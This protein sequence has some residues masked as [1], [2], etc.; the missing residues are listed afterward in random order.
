MDKLQ[1]NRVKVVVGVLYRINQQNNL[2]LLFSTRPVNKPYANYWEF[3]GGKIEENEDNIT[4]LSRELKEELN[5]DICMLVL[6]LRILTHY[7]TYEHANV[8]LYFYAINQWSGIPIGQEK[9]ELRWCSIENLPQPLIPSLLVDDVLM[10]I[11][12][13]ICKLLPAKFIF[14]TL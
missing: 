3:A 1:F 7:H 6:P 14:H 11:N 12:E 5:I 4:A 8:E 10:R 2:E 13:F 9:Q